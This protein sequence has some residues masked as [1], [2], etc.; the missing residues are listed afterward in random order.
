[1]DG[2]GEGN[3]TKLVRFRFELA[4]SQRDA[5]RRLRFHCFCPFEPFISSVQNF[6]VVFGGIAGQV[7]VVSVCFSRDFDSG[8]FDKVSEFF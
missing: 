6:L 5:F 1:M 8:S 4:I 3:K 2:V 7:E